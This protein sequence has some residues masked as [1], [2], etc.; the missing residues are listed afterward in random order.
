M[1]SGIGRGLHLVFWGMYIGVGGRVQGGD[2]GVGGMWDYWV[3]WMC[4]G[5][6][7]RVVAGDG[8]LG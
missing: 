1:L 2:E 7:F 3:R 5:K 6:K 4:L 8:V